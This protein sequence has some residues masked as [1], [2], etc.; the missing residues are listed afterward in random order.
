MGDFSRSTFRSSGTM[1]SVQRESIHPLLMSDL[2]HSLHSMGVIQYLLAVMFLICYAL[3][4]GGF[5]GP[6]ARYGVAAT[7][8]LSA[9]GFSALADYWVHGVLLTTFVIV[10][11][12]LFIGVAWL[13][14]TLVIAW[15]HRSRARSLAA[16]ASLAEGQA[17]AEP[18][19]VH[20][21]VASADEAAS[22]T[23]DAYRL[24]DEH[25]AIDHMRS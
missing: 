4:L 5:L 7:G 8:L 17:A 18:E 24:A 3:T 21:H 14:K 23:P 10:G 6:Q 19:C 9:A 15:Q 25:G 2:Q 22:F 12:G 16:A 1:Q 20:A 13:L 11:M